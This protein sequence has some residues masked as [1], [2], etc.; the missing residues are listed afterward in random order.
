MK[1]RKL[2]FLSLA[3][4]SVASIPLTVIACKNKEINYENI[5]SLSAKDGSLTKNVKDVNSSDI[6]VTS[7]DKNYTAEIK[8]VALVNNKPG[9]VLVA[10]DIKD[11]SGNVV[12]ADMQKTVEGFK[13]T[14]DLSEKPKATPQEDLNLIILQALTQIKIPRLNLKIHLILQINSLAVTIQLAILPMYQNLDQKNYTI[15]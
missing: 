11:K 4:T 1:K 15:T 12:L 13:T 2:S 9:T 5:I 6:Q 7:S 8:N 3:L 10:L 14:S